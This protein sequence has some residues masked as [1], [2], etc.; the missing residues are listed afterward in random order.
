MQQE[1]GCNKFPI[2]DLVTQDSADNDSKTESRESGPTDGT[3]LRICKIVGHLPIV[4][5]TTAN[6]ETDP[7]G[8][9]RHKPCPQQSL[10]I[11]GYT[12][13]VVNAHC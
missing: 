7:C 9:D 8:K 13:T 11:R 5:N 1:R 2:A 10:R 12:L 6:R 3:S 4:K